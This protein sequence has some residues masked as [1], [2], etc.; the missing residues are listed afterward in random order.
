[1]RAGEPLS[2][3]VLD[4]DRFKRVND[5]HGHPTGDAVLRQAGRAIL[6][7]LRHGDTV[8]RMEGAVARMGGEEFAILLPGAGLEQAREVAERVLDA[9]RSAA[10]PTGDG[11][12]RVTASLGIA[13]GPLA[14][15]DELYARADR[16]M[17]AAKAAGR[18]Q[19]AEWAPEPPARRRGPR[20]STVNP[21]RGR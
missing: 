8:A 4:L 18:D 9:I 16:A 7:T 11:E 3:L 17:Y 2:L 12:V 13:P 1:L 5:R 6:A 20:R 19:V 15:A 21:G 14:S 10:V